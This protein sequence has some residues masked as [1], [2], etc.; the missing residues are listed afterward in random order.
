MRGRHW[1]QL[2]AELGGLDARPAPGFT[3]EAALGR[4]L[5]AHLPAISRVADVASKE[6][7]IEQALDKLAAEWEGAQLTVVD[8][9]DSGTAVL[10][11]DDAT[12]AALDDGIVLCQSMAASPYKA[13]FAERLT[14]WAG[15]LNL[16]RRPR[17]RT[18]G[19]PLRGLTARCAG[20]GRA[21]W[22]R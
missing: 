14:K 6:F 9:R 16:V 3:L 20:R 11:L 2:S 17:A 1:D 12:A 21:S 7:S 13:A 22:L 10:R 15:T 19:R 8:F 18:G 5:L 4:G